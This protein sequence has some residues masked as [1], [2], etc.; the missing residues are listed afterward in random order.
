MKNLYFCLRPFL[1]AA[2][3][4]LI[5]QSSAISAPSIS[6]GS[7][8]DFIYNTSTLAKRIYNNGDSTAFVRVTIDEIVYGD[9]NESKEI[10]LDSEALISGKGSGLISSPSRLIIPVDGMQTNRLMF[11]GE[12][13]H[14]RYYRVRY[15]P[16]VPSDNA[17][18]GLSL[19]E[20]KEYKDK[21]SA[22]VMVLTGFGSIVTV[23]PESS[24]FDTLIAGKGNNLRITN[25]GNT[26]IFISD[27]KYCDNNKK[28]CSAA[29]NI[30]LRPGRV[31]TRSAPKHLTWQY[32]LTEGDKKQSLNNL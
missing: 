2:M 32:T 19:N 3:L 27:L 5:I 17:E 31:F 20:A 24:K 14:E 13:K 21:I 9:D 6:I 15:I 4:T 12:R 30:Q 22:G 8:T 29:S 18:F 10:P 1:F 11:T 23:A 26:S 16:V 28:N 25:N 7:M